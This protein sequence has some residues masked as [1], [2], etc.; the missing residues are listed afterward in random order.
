M[1]KFLA[2]PKLLFYALPALMLMLVI[3]TLMQGE[4]GLYQATEQYFSSFILWIGMVP[5]PGGYSILALITLNLM[6]K[7]ILDSSWK[8][9]HAGIILTHIAILILFIGAGLTAAMSKEG[10]LAFSQGDTRSEMS[11]YFARELIIKRDGQLIFLLPQEALETGKKIEAANLPFTITITEYCKHCTITQQAG[12]GRGLAQHMKLEP[13]PSRLEAEENQSGVMFDI[14]G[15]KDKQINGRY[16]SYE[17][18]PK[19]PEF[20]LDEK[21]YQ[22]ALKKAQHPLPF[23]VELLDFRK[24]SYPGTNQAEDYFSTVKITDGEDSW[25]SVISM[26]EPLR[27]RGYSLFQSSFIQHSDKQVS[28][29]AVVKNISRIFPY[30][31]GIMLCIGLM[32][33]LYLRKKASS[34]FK[35]QS[36]ESSIPNH[37]KSTTL[38]LILSCMLFPLFPQ[39]SNA[40]DMSAF[41]QLPVLH[42]GRIQPMEAFARSELQS[43]SGK[44]SLE[45]QEAVYWLTETLFTPAKAANLPLFLVQNSDI[46]QRLDLPKK[47]S[48][49]YYTQTQLSE[50]FLGKLPSIETA[51]NTSPER[52]NKAQQSLLESYA[53]FQH[54]LQLSSSLTPLLPLK[55]SLSEGFLNQFKIH[56]KKLYTYRSLLKHR[57]SIQQYLKANPNAFYTQE[58]IAFLFTIDSMEKQAISNQYLRVI[59]AINQTQTILRSPWEIMQEGHGSPQSAEALNL[60]KTLAESYQQNHLNL[61]QETSQKLLKHSTETLALSDWKQFQLKLEIW[62]YQFTPIY[63]AMWLYLLGIGIWGGVSYLHSNAATDSR[64]LKKKN[65]IRFAHEA[66]FYIV[67]T[68]IF[69][70]LIGICMRCAIMLRPPVSNLYESILFV[71]LIAAIYGLFQRR[72]AGIFTTAIA[73][74]ASLLLTSLGFTKDGDSLNV[75]VAVLNT[76]FWLATHVICITTGYACCLLTGSLAHLWL[77]SEWRVTSG[78]WREKLITQIKTLALFSLLFTAIGTLLGGIW[79]DQSWG[80]FWG[81]DP[82]E[83][84]ALLIVLWLIWIIHGRISKDLSLRGY[85][86]GLAALNIIVAIAWFGV[87]LLGIG[88]HSY[89]FTDGAIW[90]FTAFCV[91]ECIIIATLYFSTKRNERPINAV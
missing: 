58:A 73:I 13:L 46:R 72:N 42:Q 65:A 61:W 5:L 31:S 84:G 64:P 1:L 77:W 41:R 86:A 9:D 27:Y 10:Y 25:Q 75:L 11:D 54:Y 26:N 56:Y 59:P 69:L 23:T 48:K 66:G 3:G 47:T 33:H 71:S 35:T 16:L 7:L 17:P 74:A 4:I 40:F 70:H 32:L 67:S 44:T 50:A 79:A 57:Q 6:A 83:N 38:L 21:R 34:E 49:F 30:L 18:L 37:I 60:W 90:G 12:E 45:K 24:Q 28:I 55:L 85:M 82:K 14:S 63:W 87:N 76:N 22:I 29:L 15:A 39:P 81:W 19:S 89:G 8:R 52:R 36:S 2:Q 53:A 78:E 68:A 51:L 91:I 43:F 88:L 20:T 80:R 62:Y